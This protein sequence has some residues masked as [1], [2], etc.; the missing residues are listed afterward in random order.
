VQPSIA[1]SIACQPHFQKLSLVFF[2][3]VFHTYAMDGIY[4]GMDGGGTRCRLAVWDADKNLIYEDTGE[5]SNP[6]AVGFQE[7]QDHVKQL[8]SPYLN[9]KA[10]T[11]KP[12]LG[13]CFGSAG[14]G[15]KDEHQ[16]WEHFFD[17]TFPTLV[18]RLLVSDATLLLAGSHLEPTGLC[19]ICG[20]GSICLGRNK[21]GM[22]VRSGGL[23]IALGDEGSGWWIAHEAIKRCYRSS[24]GRDLQTKM[25]T[26]LLS[27]YGFS[28]LSEGIP[29]FNDRSRTKAEIAAFATLVGQAAEEGD[30]LALSIYA[31]AA[32]ELAALVG[33]VQHR[34]AEPYPKRLSLAGGVLAGDALL[35]SMV[36]KRLDPRLAT[37]LPKAGALQGALIL[38]SRL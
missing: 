6:Y 38:A 11:D 20:T 5:S 9:S 30:E 14:L 28:S 34:L 36:C 31:E 16:R 3:A 4:L 18:P 32:D 35:R 24:E 17:Q 23:G 29:Y 37:S 27:F 26:S 19:L 15:R 25:T 1:Q 7:A 22:E 13:F 8:L 21:T 12:I 10:A 33:S 2:P